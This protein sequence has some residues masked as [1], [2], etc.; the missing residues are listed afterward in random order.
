MR[1]KRKE[2]KNLGDEL[3]RLRDS[4]HLSQ[5][6]MA[7]KLGVGRSAVSGCEIGRIRLA[8]RTLIKL[9]EMSPSEEQRLFFLEQMGLDRDTILR[10]A[11]VAFK[12]Q[13]EPP[14]AAKIMNARSYHVGDRGLVD[15]G[16]DVPLPAKFIPNPKATICM[17]MDEEAKG[18]RSSPRGLFIVDRSGADTE[19]LL[20]FLGR[21]VVMSFTP[22]GP[23]DPPAGIYVGRISLRRRVWGE[24]SREHLHHY[25]ELDLLLD[26]GPEHQVSLYSGGFDFPFE[27]PRGAAT[28]GGSRIMDVW[29]WLA[30]HPSREK[31][32]FEAEH[33]ALSSARLRHGC[34]LIGEVIGSL[35]GHTK[36]PRP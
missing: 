20:S 24:G 19:H 26:R 32:F 3:A 35:S 2:L 11:D 10:A 5:E 34:R 18:V 30:G 6:E 4:L 21:V 25:W 7:Q 31:L 9:M 28:P 23:H 36:P 8:P 13:M 14:A 15:A 1:K 27:V 16:E 22:A 17:L 33:Q 29:S 12:K